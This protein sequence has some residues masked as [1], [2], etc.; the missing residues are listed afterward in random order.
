MHYIV[1]K[2][3]KH[4]STD[5]TLGIQSYQALDLDGRQCCYSIRAADRWL[6][7]EL[8]WDAFYPLFRL[9]MVAANTL[10]KLYKQ[11][12]IP[13]T[14]L[15]VTGIFENP[16]QIV[17]CGSASKTAGPKAS[18]WTLSSV[19]FRAY[20]IIVIIVLYLPIGYHIF[21]NR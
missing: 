18:L 14:K 13:R 17:K 3:D 15:K 1:T 21:L 10:S 12:C 7:A 19:N 9:K 8:Y 11:D 5:S 2:Y 4:L 20:T 16:W 6:N